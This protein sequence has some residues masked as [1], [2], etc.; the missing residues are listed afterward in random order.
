MSH[1]YY[2]TRQITAPSDSTD[3]CAGLVF[4]PPKG[5]DE[6]HEALKVAYPF[7]SNLSSRMRQA[8]IDFLLLE[9]QQDQVQFESPISNQMSPEY[10]PSP[11]STFVSTM[12]S[13]AISGSSFSNS[14][15][16]VTP[17]AM[18]A[19][20]DLM[21]VWSLPSKP[22][23]K[24]HT[25]R[26]MT[27]EEKKAYKQKRLIGACADC[28]RRRR[29]CD[30]NNDSS[31]SP[32]P[33]SSSKVTKKKKATPSAKKDSASFPVTFTAPVFASQPEQ[34]SFPV[35]QNTMSFDTG[36][37]IFAFPGEMSLDISSGFNLDTTPPDFDLGFDLDTDFP[38]FPEISTSGNMDM[39]MLPTWQSNSDGGF[40]MP[41]RD[42]HNFQV[43]DGFQLQIQ[44]VML[45]DVTFANWPLGHVLDTR[46][47]P[48]TPQSL[49]TPMSRTQ[50]GSS[51]PELSQSNVPSGTNSV[52]S[53]ATQSTPLSRST[54]DNSISDYAAMHSSRGLIRDEA[55]TTSFESTSP[56]FSDTSY[57]FV[58]PQ[59]LYEPVLSLE[60]GDR[61]HVPSP[62]TSVS[63]QASPIA[64][65]NSNELRTT[66]R[67]A[68]AART[69]A[70]SFHTDWPD[71][72][73]SQASSS[74]QNV[75]SN[76]GGLILTDILSSS[77]EESYE[78][79]RQ[80]PGAEIASSNLSQQQLPSPEASIATSSNLSRQQ[81]L[82]PEESSTTSSSSPTQLARS[83][84]VLGSS[85]G[86]TGM[87][88]QHDRH[89]MSAGL[90]YYATPA[91]QSTSSSERARHQS[92]TTVLQAS[93]QASMA[94]KTLQDRPH[95]REQGE[96]PVPQYIAS[97]TVLLQS[98]PTAWSS[99]GSSNAE[100]AKFVQ[101]L[102][103]A[104]LPEH[105]QESAGGSN[106][107]ATLLVLTCLA[108]LGSQNGFASA[109]TVWASVALVAVATNLIAWSIKTSTDVFHD[110][111][112][113]NNCS[114]SSFATWLVPSVTAATCFSY[115]RFHQPAQPLGQEH[116][117]NGNTRSS[118]VKRS[119]TSLSAFAR[120]SV[121]HVTARFQKAGRSFLLWKERW[122]CILHA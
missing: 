23:A 30:H 16:P 48:L 121:C 84:G 44:D 62:S 78:I 18:P 55:S 97:L 49:D 27:A 54:S 96:A 102:A 24:I 101:P 34:Y 50:S 116:R 67:P 26:T 57:T 46:E 119:L 75:A 76:S 80:S 13:P 11:Q 106:I 60:R 74:R 12:P 99:S 3:P 72:Q 52:S 41:M 51:L 120:Q 20:Q 98:P 2:I 8:V 9:Q 89:V 10:L 73:R 6:L 77:M 88:N 110:R 85:L 108:Q 111:L 105:A 4:F 81:L 107:I 114:S 103:T 113:G 95:S 100:Q 43:Q 92:G 31:T 35:Q 87:R 93:L 14:T 64:N 122:L 53:S 61:S 1:S 38:L 29:K 69:I 91:T 39:P 94:A 7:E 25:R 117:R 33:A 45:H 115:N 47:Q 66:E 40:N 86:E 32:P 36:L 109:Y 28:K 68:P 37:D 17:V 19:Q 22:L 21:D 79:P 42:N 71:Q 90:T 83:T 82:S 15:V 118:F 56:T 65:A 112:S 5:S 104:M 58:D 63:E 70:G 59:A